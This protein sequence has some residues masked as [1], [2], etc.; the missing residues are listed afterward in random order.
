[1]TTPPYLG[2]RQYHFVLL[3]RVSEGRGTRCEGWGT[4]CERG[5]PDVRGGAPDVR[6]GHP[7]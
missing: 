3:H 7:M 5:A 1:M 2:T 6:E 4:R